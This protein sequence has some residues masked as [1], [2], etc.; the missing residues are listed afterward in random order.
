[1]RCVPAQS[2]PPGDLPP[3]WYCNRSLALFL[4]VASSNETSKYSYVLSAVQFSPPLPFWDQDS[5]MKTDNLIKPGQRQLVKA[6]TGAAQEIASLPRVGNLRDEGNFWRYWKHLDFFRP[7][8][9]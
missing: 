6:P 7:R 9:W 1:M 8:Y 4:V 5:I 3:Q 2:T